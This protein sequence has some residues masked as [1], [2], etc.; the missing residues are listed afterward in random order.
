M[1]S[2]PQ[3]PL[4]AFSIFRLCSN[5]GGRLSFCHFR[6]LLTT[7]WQPLVDLES[8]SLRDSGK[9]KLQFHLENYAW[10][11][12]FD[13]YRVNSLRTPGKLHAKAS[14][15]LVERAKLCVIAE[16]KIKSFSI[17]LRY[18]LCSHLML[19]SF[20]NGHLKVCKLDLKEEF[21]RNRHFSGVHKFRWKKE[22]TVCENIQSDFVL[23]CAEKFV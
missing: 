3:C 5:L 7:F 18:V 14:I 15:S 20:R 6:T 12:T 2:R 13:V 19:P 11:K 23:S 17:T 1:F 16:R 10:L 21:K 4:Q 22:L 8:N 9:P